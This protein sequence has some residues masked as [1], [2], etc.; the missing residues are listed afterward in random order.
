MGHQAVDDEVGSK[1]STWCNPSIQAKGQPLTLSLF[2]TDIRS[3]SGGGLT[4]PR[5]YSPP[6][7]SPAISLQKRRDIAIYTL[8]T[9]ER[10]GMLEGW[11]GRLLN[12]APCR[13]LGFPP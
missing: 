6:E 3:L 13:L 2:P 12:F 10:E 1:G 7:P 5:T 8:G 4:A 9:G 11:V